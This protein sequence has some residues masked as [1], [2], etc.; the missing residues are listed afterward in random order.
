MST[1]T[2]NSGAD[3][4]ADMLNGMTALRRST[5]YTPYI[6]GTVFD[7]LKA[8]DPNGI[9]T[10]AKP[11]RS[12]LH[13]QGGYLLTHRKTLEVSDMNGNRYRVTIEDMRDVE[14]AAR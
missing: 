12:H 5:S 8:R 7:A 1:Q 9:I 3:L 10:E 4:I 14:R 11:Y 6:A 13:P 2:P